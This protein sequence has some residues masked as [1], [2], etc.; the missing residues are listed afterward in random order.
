MSLNSNHFEDTISFEN[1]KRVSLFTVLPP[2]QDY[3]NV[4]GQGYSMDEPQVVPDFGDLVEGYRESRE[5]DIIDNVFENE[6]QIRSL[7]QPNRENCEFPRERISST[8]SEGL[9]I[10]LK[11]CVLT[12]TP[13]ERLY[14]TLDI[15]ET[16]VFKFPSIIGKETNT[17]EPSLRDI[18]KSGSF[19]TKTLS[20]CKEASEACQYN[21]LENAHLPKTQQTVNFASENNHSWEEHRK[22]VFEVR[23]GDDSRVTDAIVLEKMKTI[24][25]AV[26]PVPNFAPF[27]TSENR[28]SPAPTTHLNSVLCQDT[29]YDKNRVEIHECE[30]QKNWCL[31]C[32]NSVSF[33]QNFLKD[34]CQ[35]DGTPNDS[36]LKRQVS[37][38]KRNSSLIKTGCCKQKDGFWSRNSCKRTKF[39]P[40]FCLQNSKDEK[41]LKTRNY[42]SGL[43]ESVTEQDMNCNLNK[44]NDF[45]KVC[46]NVKAFHNDTE[47]QRREN[48]KNKLQNL[49]LVI[50]ELKNQEKISKIAILKCAQ[51]YICKLKNEMNELERLKLEEKHKNEQLF[52]KLLSLSNS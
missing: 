1:R 43:N 21:R 12:P 37:I 50:P 49:R 6:D 40:D 52:S 51:K 35:Q 23:L 16:T 2:N 18:L 7:Y 34:V 19:Q 31:S 15:A 32:D 38:C 4:V 10:Y 14:S 8:E 25:Q 39:S 42:F 48:M 36:M 44:K 30:K 5:C 9:E 45:S 3:P 46:S 11:P 26:S 41:N 27:Q 24:N 22:N 29:V 17:E 28:A 13:V 20:V 33:C 47:R